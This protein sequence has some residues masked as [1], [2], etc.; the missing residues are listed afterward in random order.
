LLAVQLVARLQKDL[1]IDLPL[2]AVYTGS[3]TV[4]ELARSI[5][6]FQLGQLDTAEYASLLAE[7]ETLTDEEAEALLVSEQ[8]PQP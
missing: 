3:L 6:I 1:A 8:E 5:E 4:A 7:I 2:E